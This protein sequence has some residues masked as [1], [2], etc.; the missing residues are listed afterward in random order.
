MG[1]A[2]EDY[3]EVQIM[4]ATQ[5]LFCTVLSLVFAC[6][7]L[8]AEEG[9]PSAS[10]IVDDQKP[11]KRVALVIGNSAYEI[12][13]L[14]LPNPVNDARALSAL[15]KTLDFDVIEGLNL[16]KRAMDDRIAQFAEKAETAEVT[17]FYYAGHGMQVD[18]RNY[19]LP[20][21]AEP[22]TIAALGF[23]T[24]KLDEIFPVMVGPKRIGIALLDACR[25]NPLSRQFSA[26]SRSAA[27]GRGLSIPETAAGGIFIGFAT[28]PGETA[29]DG[30][31]PNSPFAAAL[32]KYLG[33]PGIEIGQTMKRVMAEVASNTHNG[34]RPWVHSDITTDFYM[35]PAPPENREVDKA[36]VD[37]A[38]LTDE[39]KKAIIV[40]Q[41]PRE[42]GDQAADER[43]IVEIT[44]SVDVDPNYKQ[45][46]KSQILAQVEKVQYGFNERWFQPATRTVESPF[47]DFKYSIKVW[48]ITQVKVAVYLKNPPELLFFGGSMNL[49]RP[50]ELTASKY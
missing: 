19:I 10:P 18:G 44:F 33:A 34:Q 20:I 45:K 9:N 47:D 29:D 7:T 27:V 23:Q 2:M 14:A 38:A 22:K 42:T 21:D 6:L 13:T 50:S 46:P 11:G 17:L 32:L 39:D 16:D 48:G 12:T 25:N 36:E 37:K 28:A 40:R 24:V 35:K 31:G 3:R 43:K 41:V 5:R 15:L 26:V 30:E 8:N 1:F 4:Y 49:T